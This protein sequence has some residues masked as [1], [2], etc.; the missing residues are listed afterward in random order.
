MKTLFI[1]ARPFTF[2]Q[3]ILIFEDSKEVKNEIVSMNT[4]EESII[5]LARSNNIT[6]VNIAGPK[7]YTKGIQ[8]KIQKAELEKYSEN[9]LKINLV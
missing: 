6:E 4:L 8:K 1:Y 3:N 5:Y 7:I 2:N 9:T